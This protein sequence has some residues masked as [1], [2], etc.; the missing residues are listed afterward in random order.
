MSNKQ[1][2]LIEIG[3]P[4]IKN[5]VFGTNKLK[6]IR[7]ASAL[8]SYLNHKDFLLKSI[9]SYLSDVKCIFAGGGSA[10]FI[11]KGTEEEVENC[12]NRLANTFSQETNY[13]LKLIYGKADLSKDNYKI[14]RKVAIFESNRKRDESPIENVPML[15]VGYV[16]ECDSCSGVIQYCEKEDKKHF[17][18]TD[19]TKSD[20][21]ILCNICRRKIDYSSVVKNDYNSALKEK[22]FKTHK[23]NIK[24]SEDFTQIGDSCKA[25]KNY[26]AVVYADG[27][28]MGKLIQQIDSP[29]LYE[30]F[31][32]TVDQAIKDSCIEA[33]C[34]VYDNFYKQSEIFP[35]EILLLGG[36]DLIVYLTA[37]SAFDFALNVAKK[38]NEKTEIKFNEYENS[39]FKDL[40]QEKGLTI[41]LGI[42]Y[43][44]S[45]TP[46]N[47]LLNQAEQLLKSAKTAGAKD[48]DSTMFYAPTYIDY[49]I[50]TNF[51]QVDVSQL[52]KEVL[53]LDKTI[54]EDDKPYQKLKL[55]QKPYSLDNAEKLYEYAQNLV[56]KIPNSRL[57]RFGVAPNL[58]KVNATLECLSLYTGSKDSSQRTAIWE[59]LSQ[60]ECMEEMPWKIE[61][62][63]TNHY[64]TM[65]IDLV[66]LADFIKTTD[67]QVNNAAQH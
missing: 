17:E 50:L 32:D 16:R 65:I 45:H 14:A 66:E 51:N 61:D 57:K 52:R 27:N 41:S 20:D 37:E 34:D 54:I 40:L 44:K 53:H 24:S 5:Y 49:N 12:M 29:D 23:K 36:D 67:D 30:F 13:G 25:R 35:A 15:H 11:V 1:Q 60:F 62:Q 31:S 2:Y 59:A 21:R 22:I 55:Y 38:F 10:Q 63:S 9:E 64:S 43:G 56:E 33:L 19:K 46:F 39:F 28:S 47:M 48:P 18:Q 58:G 4:S 7:G 6:E 26:T 3:V 42:A 8:L